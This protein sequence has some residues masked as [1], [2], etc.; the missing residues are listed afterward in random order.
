LRQYNYGLDFCESSCKFGI[1]GLFG[2]AYLSLSSDIS[3]VR[4]FMRTNEN[5]L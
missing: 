4:V 1:K 5:S 2:L 3:F